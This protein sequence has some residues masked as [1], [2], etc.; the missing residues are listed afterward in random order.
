[1]DVEHLQTVHDHT[2]DIDEHKISSDVNNHDVKDCHHCGHCSGSHTS[3]IVVKPYTTKLMLLN[4]YA[5]HRMA[6]APKDISS[7]IYRPP[8]A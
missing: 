4:Y 5:I 8:I 2:N 3:W 7:R 6:P 1:M